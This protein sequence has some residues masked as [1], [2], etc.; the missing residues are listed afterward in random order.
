[1]NSR[2][3]KLLATGLLFTLIA[4]CGGGSGS[5]GGNSSST[6]TSSS[7]GGAPALPTISI[8]NS[9]N[10][11]GNNNS[12][13]LL[14]NVKLSDVTTD[15]VSVEYSINESSATAGED[16]LGSDGILTIPAGDSNNVI[17]VEI[18]GDLCHESDETFSI[19]LSN[20]VNA[21]LGTS[22]ATGTIMNDDDK[23][24][25]TLADS[26]LPEGDSGTSNMGFIVSL[27]RPSCYD[28]SGDFATNVVTANSLDFLI[29]TGTFIIPAGDPSVTI[30]AEITGDKFYE[31]DETLTVNLEN[32]SDHIN[33][34]DGEAFGTI[35]TDDLPTLLIQPAEVVEGDTTPQT[36]LFPV[37][38]AGITNEI[39]FDFSTE[40]LTA[41]VDDNDYVATNGTLTI[42]AGETSTTIEVEV[43]GDTKPELLEELKVALSNLVGDA[44][45][46]MGF[47]FALG[48]IFDNDT[49]IVIDPVVSVEV[50][51][52]RESPDNYFPVTFTFLANATVTSDIEIDYSTSDLSAEAGSDYAAQTGTVTIPAGETSA[53]ITIDVI[54]DPEIENIEYF[55]L[56]LTQVSGNLPLD[57]PRATG[58][59]FDDDYV[60]PP[61]LSANWY[62]A[63]F[64]GNSG[65]HDVLVPVT[66]SA[67][68]TEIVTVDYVTRDETA[69]ADSDYMAI[70]GTVTFNPGETLQTISIPVYGDTVIEANETLILELSN[71]TDNVVFF[72]DPDAPPF[73]SIET[74]EPFAM[75]SIAD[76]ALLEGDSGTTEMEFTVSIDA[77]AGDPVTMDYVSADAIEG[78]TATEDEDYTPVAGSIS[79]PAGELETTLTVQIN[80]DPINEYDETF[81]ILLSNVSQ[82][83]EFDNDIGVGKIINDDSGPGWDLPQ[84]MNQNGQDNVLPIISMN[85]DGD[86]M[87]VWGPVFSGYFESS[88]YTPAGGWSTYDLLT[89]DFSSRDRDLFID[90]NGDT[91][92][93]W[94]FGIAQTVRH[95]T[96]SNWDNFLEFDP[97]SL[98]DQDYMRLAGNEAGSVLAVWKLNTSISTMVDH[99]MYSV[100]D[101]MLEEW[102]DDDFLVFESETHLYLPQIAMNNNG[103]AVA[104]WMQGQ[105][106]ASVYDAVTGSWSEPDIIT[107]EL[108]PDI[109]A[110]GY[111]PQ[112]AMDDNGYAIAV[113]DDDQGIGTGAN[114]RIWASRY[115]PSTSEWSEA[116]RLDSTTDLDVTDAQIAMDAAGN[117]FV[118]WMQDNDDTDPWNDS[119]EIRA[120]RYDVTTGDWEP[121]VLL[122]DPDT[123]VSQFGFNIQVPL[124]LPALAVD[125]AGNAIVA[126]SEEIQP[127]EFVIRACRYD[128]SEATPAWSPPEKISG[129]MYPFAIFPD[130]AVDAAGN[131]IVV[132]QM[133]DDENFDQYDV[134]EIWWNRFTAP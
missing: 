72:Y 92:L 117:A 54:D 48:K 8:A 97:S 74:D 68:A 65:T 1:M 86:A 63:T 3:Y 121:E 40:D 36:L 125:P 67:P 79:I 100:Y 93:A 91:T 5:G 17:A 21:T 60:G 119:F 115:D 35:R 133:G 104:V 62:N 83:A 94:I 26:E 84:V 39:S 103:D 131:A 51:G 124:D 75:A 50:D 53:S 15:D 88:R 98:R 73:V 77:V 89:Q 6:S 90:G 2:L 132:W 11:E 122:H 134:A 101:P 20:P 24:E 27:S 105:I 29:T 37:E 116:R 38:L 10:S 70:S 110:G 32:V 13:E 43:I 129:D 95:T 71:P 19:V 102:T 49:P 45:L 96:A 12:F 47:D 113:W 66:L 33:V 23:P 128:I 59:I 44:V 112:V 16:Y 69:L 99:L 87:A 109:Y 56:N 76:V 78:N 34:V 85:V 52:G 111:A 7:S 14:F 114:G 61:L 126:W 18:N 4:A 106:R 107:N 30:N 58:L 127:D 41:T 22:T 55:S 64:E 9:S 82:N 31:T 25:L 108:A 123:R 57:T 118:I 42:P 46:V 81:R 80:G 130:I 28:V 120:R